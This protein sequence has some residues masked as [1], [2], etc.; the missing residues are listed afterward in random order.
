MKK[1]KFR[2]NFLVL[3]ANAAF[4]RQEMLQ[5]ICAKNLSY[6]PAATGIPA[7]AHLRMRASAPAETSSAR[8]GKRP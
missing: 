8:G 6:V 4:P 1:N 7:P 5:K 2:A 3:S